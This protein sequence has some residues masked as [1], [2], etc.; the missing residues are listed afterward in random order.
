MGSG[1]GATQIA[2]SGSIPFDTRVAAGSAARDAVRAKRRHAAT[3][4][5]FRE[6][7]FDLLRILAAMQVMIIHSMARL[8]IPVPG[9]LK[10]LE[11]FPGVPI[12]FIISG[13]LVSA[14]LERQGNLVR[15]F[16][17]R[18]LRIYPGL[19]VCVL[20]TVILTTALGYRPSLILDF[21]WLP[22]QLLA[23]IYT[24]EYLTH[25]GAGTYNGALWTIP[26]ELQFYL[27]LPAVYFVW[28]KFRK[29][30]AVIPVLCGVF[31]AIS[32]ILRY[33]LPGFETPQETPVDKLVRYTFAGSFYL[34][35]FGVA[36]QR[37]RVFQ[38]KLI[39]GKGLF[40]IA[41]YVL[42]RLALPQELSPALSVLSF[43]LLGITA[44]SFAYTTPK[45][46]EAILH[47]Q[48]ISYGVY[49][50]H[51]LIINLL[52]EFGMKRSLYEVGLIAIS[53]LIVGALSW[54]LVELPFL[55]KKGRRLE[56]PARETPAASGEVESA[57]ERGV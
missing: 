25:F 16:K 1:R 41:A 56:V 20:I 57:L 38:S 4:S 46:S 5:A 40:W 48:D 51:G 23:V 37:F 12:F 42:L 34:F 31:I 10:W 49:I 43:L 7:N 33:A 2:D 54:K 8:G 30:A 13:Y 22:A 52:I 28:R 53:S 14:S 11:W 21:L 39:A 18:W 32:L 26:I 45:A 47:G 50:Y 15:Y 35:L 3:E 6:N 17:N 36:L 19:W 9:G 55:R 29:S 44:V 24:P 27:L